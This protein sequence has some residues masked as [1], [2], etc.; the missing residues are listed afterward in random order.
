MNL[1]N[2]GNS[3]DSI[4]VIHNLMNPSNNIHSRT[5]TQGKSVIFVSLLMKFKIK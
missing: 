3:S 4:T 5:V 2:P 1:K